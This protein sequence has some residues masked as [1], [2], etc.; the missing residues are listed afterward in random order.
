[1]GHF[2]A[3]FQTSKMWKNFASSTA[4]LIL[5]IVKSSF[6]NEN[7]GGRKAKLLPIFQVVKFPND[8]CSGGSRNGTCFTSEECSARNGI[9]DGTCASGFGV[10]CVIAMSCGGSTSNNNSYI[11][12]SS[13]TSLT[14][15]CTYT[16]CPCSTDICR[17]RYDFTTNTL[18]APVLQ[19]ASNPGTGL[20]E[21]HAIGDCTTDQMSITS[22]GKVGSPIICGTNTDQHMIVDTTGLDCQRVNFNIGASTTTSRS[23][24][25]YVTQYTCGQ[26][27][28]AGPPGCLQY[29]T[30]T[31]GL[32][33]N[34]GYPTSNTVAASGTDHSTTHL[35]NQNYMVCVRR[36]KDYC[37]IC[38][39]A[40]NSITSDASFGVSN[41]A[42]D[43][44]HSGTGTNCVTDYVT[45]PQ[46][47][48]AT[49]AA[50]TTPAAFND[51]YC[52][53]VLSTIEANATPATV[54]S[55]SY[56]FNIGVTFDDSE[57]CAGTVTA[58][59][60]EDDIQA[61][62]LPGGILGFALGFTQMS[63]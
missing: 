19:T 40:W 29:Y 24:D 34:F 54:C 37:Y 50:T 39:A 21:S 13:T 7:E 49:I 45:I 43:M 63:C 36:E 6:A 30:G 48:T 58:I 3:R 57:I 2:I 55:R 53:R 20:E 44:S 16:V 61:A 8:V 59:V 23:W 51:R 28:V 4:V 56:P 1:M 47:T 22:P 18:S 10:C 42:A 62:D 17:I 25:I 11:V 33:K 9:N 26:E 5:V 60:C 14:S 12:Q 27:D 15:P 31:T 35:Q 41:P 38:W 32:V 46:G 52:G